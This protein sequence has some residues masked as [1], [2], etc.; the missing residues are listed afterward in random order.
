MKFLETSIIIFKH[1]CQKTYVHH[2]LCESSFLQP[3][4]L[5]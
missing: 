5:N 1:F 3:N 2:K 4:E